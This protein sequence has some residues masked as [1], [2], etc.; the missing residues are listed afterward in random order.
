[1]KIGLFPGSVPR[2][3]LR[4][5]ELMNEIMKAETDG[6]DS[7]WVPHLSAR[8]FD[9]L[10]VLALAGLRT[11]RIELGTA[12]VPT[13]PRHPTALTQQ[14]ITTQ[15]ACGGRLSLGIGPSHRPAVED[16]WGL[17]YEKPA[18]HI[19]EYLSVMNQ[20][21][22]E[23]SASFYGD[24]YRVE[25]Q[26]ETEGP[27]DVPIL[28]SALAPVML[29]IAGE[30]SNGTITWM[31]GLS[32]TANHI[33]PR[34]NNAAQQA[35]RT[36]PRVCVGLPIAVTDDKQGGREQAAKLFQRYGTLANYRRVLD[37]ESAD[38]PADVSI[39][40]NEE[41]VESKLR[42]FSNAG[43]TDFLASIFP[44]GVDEEASSRRTYTLLSKLVGNID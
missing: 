1:M 30:M 14:A 16:S 8:G 32:A 36:A 4:I 24:L 5:D 20:L 23:G 37:I 9:A 33:V 29:R 13:Y 21:V 38:G 6:F 40:G 22:E 19:R 39:I 28:I 17:S 18:H 15:A 2:A 44:V 27:K 31:S 26:L 42:E 11:T 41:E 3:L 10:T 12:V 25:A 43:A 7:F 35:G 34:I